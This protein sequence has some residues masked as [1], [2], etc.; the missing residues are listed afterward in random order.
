VC[1]SACGRGVSY[2]CPSCDSVLSVGLDPMSERSDL[3][4][5]LAQ[6]AAIQQMCLDKKIQNLQNFKTQ[7][8]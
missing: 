2:V 1:Q 8:I 6:R 7:K 4:N 3:L 5:A